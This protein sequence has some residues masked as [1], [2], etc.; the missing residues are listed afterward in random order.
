VSS[1]ISRIRSLCRYGALPIVCLLATVGIATSSLSRA[2]VVRLPV[3]PSGVG[4]TMQAT[5]AS[6][7]DVPASA[8]ARSLGL[9]DGRAIPTRL[10]GPEALRAELLGGSARPLSLASGDF[11]EDGTVDLA[12]GFATANAGA[13][14]IYRG[15]PDAVYPNSPEAQRRRTEGLHVEAPFL[16][17]AVVF[18]APMAADFLAA[19]DFDADGHLD[20]AIAARQG[21][22]IAH[23]R[24]DGKGT[25]TRGEILP[26]FGGVTTLAAGEMNA[27]DGLADIAV[28]VTG[29]AGAQLLVFEG[30]T[31]AFNAVPEA[32]ELPSE[33]V[34]FAIANIDGEDQQDLAVA[35]TTHLVVVWGRDRKISLDAPTR[36]LVPTADVGLYDLKAPPSSIAVTWFDTQG[37]RI[38]LV[39]AGGI[40][41]VDVRRSHGMTLQVSEV[42]FLE[43]EF[44][45]RVA[46]LTSF[47]TA[48]SSNDLIVTDSARRQIS[49]VPSAYSKDRTPYLSATPFA[50][51][52]A[53]VATAKLRL[54]S[55]SLD[56]LVV[57]T[58]ASPFPVVIA[59]RVAATFVVTNTNDNGAG[60]LRQGILDA[61]ANSAADQIS[62]NISGTPPF[63]ITPLT[64][65]PALAFPVTIDGTTQPGF[66]GSPVVHLDGSSAGTNSDGLVIA[67]SNGS[68]SVIRGLA[69]GRYTSAAIRISS[70]S[71]VSNC[72][73]EGNYLGLGPDGTTPAA[74]RTGITLGSG[75]VQNLAI[76]GTSPASKNVISGNNESGI[77]QSGGE[78]HTSQVFGNFIGTNASGLASVSNGLNGCELSVITDSY[79]GSSTAG[80]GNLVSGNG[81]SGI[82]FRSRIS[83]CLTAGNNIGVDATGATRLANGGSGITLTTSS[84]SLSIVVGGTV[85]S[86]RNI[87]SANL[88]GIDVATVFNNFG[89]ITIQGNYIGTGAGGSGDLGNRG[90]GVFARGSGSS[91][92]V[93]VGGSSIGVANIISGNDQNG[94]EHSGNNVLT[95]QRNFIGTNEASTSALGNT[96]AGI[97][98]TSSSGVAVGGFNVGNV[99][100]FNGGPG[101]RVLNGSANKISQNSIFDN[102]GL[103]IDLG[104]FGVE[105]NDTNSDNDGG[106]NGLQNYPVISQVSA[107]G[108]TTSIAGTLY[109]Q[110]NR[111][112]SIE[113]YTTP[114]CDPTGFGEGNTFLGET[115]VITDSQGNASFAV[116]LPGAIS[117]GSFVTAIAINNNDTSEFSRCVTT[118]TADL[119]VSSS[120]APEPILA[121]ADL[122]YSFVVTNN[123][124]SPAVNVQLTH[125]V[126]TN[127]VFQSVNAPPGWTN[128]APPQGSPGTVMSSVASLASG[129]SATIQVTVRVSATAQPAS[130]ITGSA[131]VTSATGDPNAVNNSATT[132]SNVLAQADLSLTI[133]DAPDPVSAGQNI[134]YTITITNN[135]PS[136]APSVVLT[137]NL[138]ASLTYF[139]CFATAGGSCGGSGNNRTVN[140][141]SI[142]PNSSATATIVARTTCSV[143]NGTPVTNSA[144]VTANSIDPDSENNFAST[145]TT[146][147]NSTSIAPISQNFVAA[148]G[149]GSTA[150]TSPSACTWTAASNASW[151]TIT[152]G[153]SGSGN[154]TVFYSVA[155]NGNVSQRTGTMTVAGLTLTV[156]QDGA[157]CSYIVSPTSRS[158]GSA[159]TSDFISVSSPSFCSWTSVSNAAWITI[160]GGASGSGTGT[161]TYSVEANTGMLRTGNIT[162]AGQTVTIEQDA[163]PCQC[164]IAPESGNFLAGGGQGVIQASADAGCSWSAA[165]NDSF[166]TVV[167]GASGMGN[168]TVVF[169]VAPNL[170]PAARVGTLFVAGHVY[171]VNQTA[172]CASTSSDILPGSVLSGSLAS[173]DCLG[174]VR[175]TSY[176]DTFSFDAVAGRTYYVQMN[177]SNF[178]AYLVLKNAAGTVVSQDDNSAGGSNAL[179]RYLAPAS[180]R[181]TVE[182]T[183][184]LAS[185]TGAYTLRLAQRKVRTS[186]TGV[187]RPSNAI[188]Y[189]KNQNSSGFADIYIPG[190]GIAGDKA[191]TGDWNGDGIDTIGVFRGGTFFL[192]NSNN[193]GFGDTTVAYGQAGDLPVVGDWDGDG[194]DTV[195]FYRGGAFYLRN[196]NTTGDP[197]LVFSLGNPGDVPI[198]GDWNRDG[199]DTVGVFR[200]SSAILY[201]KNTNAEGFADVF[202]PGYGIA[203]DKPVTGDWNGD[204]TDTI[205]VYRGD[206]F[207]LRNTNNSGF[208]DIT[209]SLG[210]DGDEPI[211]GDWDG[212]P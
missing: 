168:G 5:V 212:L 52:G 36:G 188:L 130:V 101:V 201:L 90:N 57:L 13:V 12:V 6:I 106:A 11:D 37:A 195:G 31:G 102:G 64:P 54:N 8:E 117:P 121:G 163:P 34:G 1:K 18:E 29:D 140:F 86:A 103:G 122:V 176:H 2:A 170:G 95:V 107:G 81:A 127:T 112:I 150:V 99:V 148:G 198:A 111:T 136:V 39:E 38:A 141:S 80:A 105:P 9:D 165:A 84:D 16:P 59:T 145:V 203:G 115:S 14:V 113:F 125:E 19:G 56:D 134:T 85:A 108:G 180:G 89:T 151:I 87:I 71:S 55:D 22:S 179:I 46:C 93:I 116:A 204:G 177:S 191:V 47:T 35:T 42:D 208:A 197:E 68:G 32:I 162:V 161:V 15:N 82:L 169:S 76:G 63:T 149:N 21:T 206:T 51:A 159:A 118:G 157:T 128:V 189:L 186:T 48:G 155:A 126:P 152:S 120:A 104:N 69:I 4:P 184:N 199:V 196:S 30:P 158:H 167:S 17:D 45:S 160:T 28:G 79:I 154:G 129:A 210:V 172:G 119:S 175:T 178:D 44:G 142:A 50:L 205:G 49:L 124:P 182:A 61:N 91:L 70:G 138:P 185:A 73:L 137:D 24:G 60:S 131:S 166:I 98:L 3:R 139:Q 192:R 153:S 43:G 133:I 65:L 123:G 193:S 171:T 187:F 174:S 143:A 183:S 135:G 190:Y 200:P 25:L 114:A 209:F 33:A 96:L 66:A 88:H 100:A 181:F 58:D 20:L 211:P 74:N 207:F 10:G 67:N 164:S 62:F 26:L 53:P 132:T 40:R 109:S 173:S 146:V 110:T 78:F 156:T 75:L 23:L 41:E 72:V 97:S 92:S 83:N 27:R 7:P 144:S 147:N 202:I 194:I 94:I 77:Y